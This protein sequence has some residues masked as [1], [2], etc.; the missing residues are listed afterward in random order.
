V[1]FEPGFLLKDRRRRGGLGC[2]GGRGGCEGRVKFL[3][4]FRV[5]FLLQLQHLEKAKKRPPVKK[6]CWQLDPPGSLG[7]K[8]EDD[9]ATF[10]L[11]SSDFYGI[12]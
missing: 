6:F 5:L 8:L 2:S 11:A 7:H 1:A 4:S 10:G 3:I 9:D 12:V